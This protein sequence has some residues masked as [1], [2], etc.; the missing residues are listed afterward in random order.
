[1]GSI[2]PTACFLFCFVF[3]VNKGLLEQSQIL[4]FCNVCG[5]F[6]TTGA[7]LRSGNRLQRRTRLLSGPLREKFADLCTVALRL[8]LTCGVRL[9]EINCCFRAES[10]DV[11]QAPRG[12]VLGSAGVDR[13]H[14]RPTPHSWIK[15]VARNQPWLGV[16]TP[17]KWANATS[18]GFLRDPVMKD[19]LPLEVLDS[20]SKWC[21]RWT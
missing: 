6:H 21:G 2:W 19:L 3:L 12:G 14:L 17:G 16:F 4:L 20:S 5:Y 1:M 7:E 8:W 13:V 15:L 18:Q 11:A 10:Q 9:F